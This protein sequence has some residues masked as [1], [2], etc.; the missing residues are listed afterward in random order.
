MC[1]D[2]SLLW[3]LTGWDIAS[4]LCLAAAVGV[5]VWALSRPHPGGSGD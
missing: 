4:G 3:G 5:F 1:V 2:S